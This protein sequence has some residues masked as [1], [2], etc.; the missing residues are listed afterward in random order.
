MIENWEARDE[1]HCVYF[2]GRRKVWKSGGG[3]VVLGG[4]NV[5]PLVEIG[6]IDLHLVTLNI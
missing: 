5:A 6:L 4:D 1:E 2:Q 3:L